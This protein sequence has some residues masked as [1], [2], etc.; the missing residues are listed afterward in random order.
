MEEDRNFYRRFYTR[1]D[2]LLLAL[3]GLLWLM[4]HFWGN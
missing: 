3:L 1:L 2:V 4:N